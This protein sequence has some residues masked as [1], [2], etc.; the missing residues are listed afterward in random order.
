MKIETFK[1]QVFNKPVGVVRSEERTAESETWETI[2][3]ISQALSGEFYKKAVDEAKK[4]GTRK[5]LSVDVFDENMQ[6]TKAPI[7]MGTVGT[8][9]FEE[10][11]MRRYE[12]KMQV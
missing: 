9:A 3:R 12:Q 11:I 4:A 10:T 2:S 6:I 7:S 5:A 8:K 1:N